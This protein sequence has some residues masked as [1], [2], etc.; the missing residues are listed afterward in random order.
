MVK[1]FAFF[2]T[3]TLRAATALSVS[4]IK[5]S[6][7]EVDDLPVLVVARR[8]FVLH[9]ANTVARSVGHVLPRP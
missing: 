1:S 9:A 6:Q 8:R 7:V 4:F 5:R 3:R 2:V